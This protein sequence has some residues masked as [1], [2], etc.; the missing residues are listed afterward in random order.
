METAMITPD[1]VVAAQRFGF[2]ASPTE[3]STIQSDPRGW[4]RAQIKAETQLPGP[5]AALPSTLDDQLAFFLWLRQY[6]KDAEA[7]KSDGTPMSV[8]KS[9]AQALYPRYQ[10]AVKARF[11]SAIGTT[12][13]VFERLVHFWS[14]HFV[15]SGAKPVAIALPP[16]FERD[17][18]RPFVTGKFNDM[19]HAVVRHPAMLIYL[20][21]VQS[22]GA[23]SEWAKHP[24]RRPRQLAA[25]PAPTGLNENLAREILELHTVGVNGGY[26]QADVTSFANVITGWQIVTPRQFAR[27]AALWAGIGKD[28]FYFNPDAHEPGAHTVMGK[29]YPAD[30][31]EQGEAVLTDLA[32]HPATAQFIATKMA[33]HF[34][35][36]DPPPAA[37]ARLAA[38][39]TETDGDLGAVTRALVDCP[40][41]WSAPGNKL[42]QPEEYLISAVRTLGGPPLQPRQLLGSLNE[43]GQR[44]YMQLGPDG[45]SDQQDYWL[46]PDAIW[47]RIEWAQ[48]AGRALAGTIAEPD[49]FATAVFGAS[50][51]ASTRTAIGRAESPAQG[52]ALLLAA[53]E[54]MRR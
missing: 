38:V 15:V 12:T 19:L 28:L 53:P 8:E 1:A 31:V 50:L 35:A 46:S 44:P 26:D 42:K 11:D 16:S 25:F 13:P 36:D 54:F 29:T 24:P 5:V 21:N 47:K 14:N 41:A 43:M 9:Y 30:G 40:E 4:V 45:W 3:M 10:A 49:A 22:I 33:R 6:R 52:I 18:I 23:H 37:V 34:I 51:S 27:F 2:G 7:A 17:A 20:D 39:F 48:L 32:H